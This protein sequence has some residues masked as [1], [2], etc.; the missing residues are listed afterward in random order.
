MIEVVE[1]EREPLEDVRPL[2]GLAQ[3]ERV[4]RRTTS[5][6]WST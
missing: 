1:R 3:V 2:L 4:R 6:R 5:C